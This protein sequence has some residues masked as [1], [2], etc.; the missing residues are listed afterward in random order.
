MKT[1]VRVDR[2]GTDQY[3]RVADR[4][5]RDQAMIRDK[6]K[7]GWKY[8]RKGDWKRD[9]MDRDADKNK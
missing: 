5:P 3:Q 9:V 4:T 7:S 6:I 2:E 8:C 1:L